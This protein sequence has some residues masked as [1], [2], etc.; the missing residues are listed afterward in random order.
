MNKIEIEIGPRFR[1]V[2]LIASFTGLLLVSGTVRSAVFE[3]VTNADGSREMR[4]FGLS[5]G[6]SAAREPPK[7][8]PSRESSHSGHEL[9]LPTP[10]PVPTQAP[11]SPQI[12]LPSPAPV[13]ASY[14]TDVAPPS[15]PPTPRRKTRRSATSGATQNSVS[16]YNSNVTIYL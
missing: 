16:I 7:P 13:P 3:N 8:S 5:A 9:P 15:Q 10:A 6:L 2:A 1:G 11:A 14:P 4:V 12:P